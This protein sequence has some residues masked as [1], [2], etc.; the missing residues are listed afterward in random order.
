MDKENN[1]Y[2][3][4]YDLKNALNEVVEKLKEVI[5]TTVQQSEERL[6]NRIDEKVQEL[7]MFTMQGFVGMGK[8]IDNVEG[9]LEGVQGQLVQINRRL[10]QVETKVILIEREL[11][12]VNERINGVDSRLAQIEFEYQQR[13][14]YYAA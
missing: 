4:K 13:F 3:T 10:G 8:Q 5:I 1:Q 14:K 12:E 2:V 11:I 6:T 9:R 7:K